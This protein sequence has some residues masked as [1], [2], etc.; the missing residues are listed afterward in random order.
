MQI[1][2]LP[3]STITSP[4]DSVTA[5]YNTSATAAAAITPATDPPRWLAAPVNADGVGAP[6]WTPLPVPFMETLLTSRDGQGVASDIDGAVRVI[7]LSGGAD[8]QEVPH[9]AEMVVVAD[10]VQVSEL[11]SFV[12]GSLLFVEAYLGVG[13]NGRKGNGCEEKLHGFDMCF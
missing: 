10:Y 12:W 9:G 4:S 11:F 7:I 2:T 6:V 13:S 1:H 5:S 8:G 3:S